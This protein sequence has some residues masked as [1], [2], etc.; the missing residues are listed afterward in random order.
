MNYA[1]NDS[2]YGTYSTQFQPITLNQSLQRKGGLGFKD[3]Q[4]G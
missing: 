2:K 3:N 1:S 4:L